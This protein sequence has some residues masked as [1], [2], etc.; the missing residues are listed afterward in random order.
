MRRSFRSGPSADA[1]F[2]V[3]GNLPAELNRFVGRDEELSGLTRRLGESR[4]VTVVGVGGVG[5]TRLALRAA[6]ALKKRYC[7]GVWLAETG[8]L[9]DPELLAHSLVEALGLTD[10]SGRPP[11]RVLAQHLATRRLLLVL[12]GF[13]QLVDAC[14]ELV[15]ELLRRAPELTVLAVGRL[16]ERPGPAAVPRQSSGTRRPSRTARKPAG[17]PTGKGGETAG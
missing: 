2:P 5:K 7:D 16:A 12:D 15:R 6:E 9:R 13:E 10:Q 4:L 17:S 8:A 3:P 1:P 11:R 14:A